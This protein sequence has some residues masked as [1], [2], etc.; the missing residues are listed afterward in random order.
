MSSGTCLPISLTSRLD[1]GT[2]AV[3]LLRTFADSELELVSVLTKGYC[4]LEV[5]NK[6]A[7]DGDL[8][9]LA[10]ASVSVCVRALLIMSGTA[11]VTME[12]ISKTKS[13]TRLKSV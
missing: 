12:K 11:W 13:A 3:K 9:G 5:S 2:L 7:I 10:N 6:S 4:P 1:L 8:Y